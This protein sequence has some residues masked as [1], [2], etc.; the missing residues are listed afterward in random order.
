VNA[1]R[2]HQQDF[3]DVVMF[4]KGGLEDALKVPLSAMGYA[5][6]E[7]P[8][9]ADAPAIGREGGLFVG[10]AEPRRN[11]GLGAGW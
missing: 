10:A 7:R 9:I 6:K 2:F 1:P 8:H 5:W 4:E 11:G 3:P